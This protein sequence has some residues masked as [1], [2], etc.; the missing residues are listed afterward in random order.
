MGQV[1]VRC[2]FLTPPQSIDKYTGRVTAL[3][4]CEAQVGTDVAET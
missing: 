2:H 1:Y 3:V 4:C